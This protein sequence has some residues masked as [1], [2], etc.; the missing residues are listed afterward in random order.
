MAWYSEGI[1]VLIFK[2]ILLDTSFHHKQFF[3]QLMSTL[4]GIS[5][6][7]DSFISDEKYTVH[8]IGFCWKW[9]L[10][11]RHFQYFYSNINI[12]VIRYL[13]VNFL[14]FI[15]GLF[16][17]FLMFVLVFL[18]DFERFLQIIFLPFSFWPSF[19][20]C[21]CISTFNGGCICLR[22]SSFILPSN[23][24]IL[25]ILFIFT[26]FVSSTV[27]FACYTLELHNFDFFINTHFWWN[28]GI[29][30]PLVL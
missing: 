3:C 7:P 26:Y 12:L 20:Q 4:S 16:R 2:Y 11:S 27:L 19:S 14:V 25:V 9:Y 28:F 24:K 17:V 1:F 22:P 10:F 30:T 15:F 5:S 8:L 18:T 23:H 29:P 6:L 13:G 21:E